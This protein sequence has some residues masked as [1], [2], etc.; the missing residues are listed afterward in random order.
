MYEHIS[1]LKVWRESRVGE[2]DT[3]ATDVNYQIIKLMSGSQF[4][5]V[6]EHFENS[7]QSLV[8]RFAKWWVA[9]VTGVHM[10]RDFSP[11]APELTFDQV[12]YF[13]QSGVQASGLQGHCETIKHNSEKYDFKEHHEVSLLD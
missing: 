13:I 6:D 2:L 9:E 5:L 7:K 4:P 10:L 1:E 12:M 11:L 3:R 8:L